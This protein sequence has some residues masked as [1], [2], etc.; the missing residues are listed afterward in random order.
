[1]KIKIKVK[2]M[3]NHVLIHEKVKQNIYNNEN[4]NTM[5]SY[6]FAS[7]VTINERHKQIKCQI[8]IY[9]ITNTLSKLHTGLT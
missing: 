2:V 9:W 8:C 6:M 1:M 4:E 5:K 3:K 7:I